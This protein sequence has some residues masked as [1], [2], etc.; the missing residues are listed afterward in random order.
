MLNL[1]SALG[2]LV[3]SG[4]EM[5]RLSG[6]S[7]RVTGLI[8]VIDDANRGVHKKR[9]VNTKN[10]QQ[11]GA[12]IASRI[13]Q[14]DTSSDALPTDTSVA[15]ASTA[16]ATVEAE[17]RIQRSESLKVSVSRNAGV[18]GVNLAAE[19]TPRW[20]MTN[21]RK[22]V[23][24]V[25]PRP[26]PTGN[27]SIAASPVLSP[28]PVEND[29]SASTKLIDR[30]AHGEEAI[31]V[32]WDGQESEAGM[33]TN[34][35]AAIVG[36]GKLARSDRMPRRDMGTGTEDRVVGGQ[37]ISKSGSVLV[38]EE[39]FIEFRDVPLVTPAGEVLIEALS[40]KVSWLEKK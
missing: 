25:M 30:V 34:I 5:A 32:G 16:A 36:G 13:N 6:F 26:P 24:V 2:R 12:S 29:A 31:L 3:L 39:R 37:A 14:T 15:A 35:E 40:F 7:S 28:V 1:S 38:K 4:R 20:A 22:R 11:A 8:D 10:R 27:G 33:E 18:A 17:V 19:D 23:G 21:A 9:G